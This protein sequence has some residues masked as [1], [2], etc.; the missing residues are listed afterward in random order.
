MPDHRPSTV[1]LASHNQG[2]IV[3]LRELFSARGIEVVGLPDIEGAPD[4]DEPYETFEENARHKALVAAEF[5]GLP[6]LADDSGLEVDALDGAPG[7]HS[8]R[9]SP[10]EGATDA[11]RRKL[12]LSK[13]IGKPQPWSARFTCT[14]ALALPDGRTVTRSGV[15]EG[16]ILP[17]ERGKSGFGYDRIF[18]VKEANQTMAELGMEQK[19]RISHRAIAAQK[20]LEILPSL[21]G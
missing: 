5:A 15:C 6:A 3:E 13:L 7:L 10:D 14:I 1:V 2:K 20:I 19:N 12:L 8:A 18:L 9:F 11:D 17:T 21:L 16:E 4:P